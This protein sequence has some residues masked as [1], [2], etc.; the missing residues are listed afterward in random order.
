LKSK[1]QRRQFSFSLLY[2]G[3]GSVYTK[4]TQK[5]MAGE[6]LEAESSES[7]VLEFIKIC[8]G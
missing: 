3:E 5:G 4:I 7:T 8:G 2:F 1:Y 6:N